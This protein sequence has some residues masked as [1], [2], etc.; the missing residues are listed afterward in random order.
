MENLLVFFTARTPKKVA[1][2]P[3]GRSAQH[4]GFNGS[5]A[6]AFSAFHFREEW[7]RVIF[8]SNN[9]MHCI[10]TWEKSAVILAI[11]N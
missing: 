2:N 1:D 10:C 3:T 5:S 6:V 4:S 11:H 7:L 9:Q 8:I